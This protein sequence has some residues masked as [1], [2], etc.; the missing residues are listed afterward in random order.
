MQQQLLSARPRFFKSDK[1]NFWLIPFVMLCLLI[2]SLYSLTSMELSNSFTNNGDIQTFF[3]DNLIVQ[4]SPRDPPVMDFFI[5]TWRGDGHW[6]TF[7]LRSIDR[8]VPRTVYRHILITFSSSER[9]YFESYLPHFTLPI[10]LRPMDDVFFKTGP[11]N[12]SYY[13]QMFAKFHAYQHSDADFFIHMD[14][15]TIF[16]EPI[17]RSDFIDDRNRIYIKRIK[18][19]DLAQ[20]FRVWQRPSQKLL[21]ESVPYET[22]TGFPFV[23]SRDVYQNAIN[24]I[25]KRHKLPIIEVVKSINEFAEF[26]TLGHYLI[27]YMPDRWV[28]NNKKSEKVIQSWSWGGLGPG[29]A[30]FYEC[31]LH[32]QHSRDC[33]FKGP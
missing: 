3:N 33:H 7:L 8:F 25:E 31:V 21:L 32:A 20:N 16:T 18:F 27:T 19:A 10:K 24:L 1:R 6:L 9:H 15:D 30:A 29:Q 23:F 5:R 4:W 22:M 11:N 12:G 2:I 26:T 28:D 14:S 17:N 13:S